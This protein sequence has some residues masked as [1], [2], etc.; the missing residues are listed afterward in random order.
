MYQ[1]DEAERAARSGQKRKAGLS[2]GDG[3]ASQESMGDVCVYIYIFTKQCLHNGVLTF[4]VKEL[5]AGRNACVKSF[6]YQVIEQTPYCLAKRK[7]SW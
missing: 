7:L 4:R 5:V 2:S 1:K 3:E 6:Q